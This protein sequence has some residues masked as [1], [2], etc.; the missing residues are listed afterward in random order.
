MAKLRMKTTF[1]LC[2]A[3]AL[4]FM[5]PAI[6]IIGY[7]VDRSIAQATASVKTEA[8]ALAL[9]IEERISSQLTLMNRMTQSLYGNMLDIIQDR[10]A[11]CGISCH[12]PKIRRAFHPARQ[13]FS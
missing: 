10:S 3:M 1:L 9:N 6:Y 8:E 2:T 5:L 11:K 7:T 4:F 12:V 13:I